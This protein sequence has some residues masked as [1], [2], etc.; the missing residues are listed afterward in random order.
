VFFFFFFESI[1]LRA[2]ADLMMRIVLST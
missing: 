1:L 2:K